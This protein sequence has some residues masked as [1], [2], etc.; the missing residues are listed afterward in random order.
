MIVNIEKYPIDTK[1]DA[2]GYEKLLQSSISQLTVQGFVALPDF[3]RPCAIDKLTSCI[4]DL[5]RRG[6]G[7]YS[8]DSHNVFLEEEGD[9]ASFQSPTNHPRN[10]LLNSSKL[11]ID[12]RH[13]APHFVELTD[14][15]ESREFINFVGSI[16][17]TELHPSADPHGRYYANVF[18]PGDGLQWHLDRSEYSVSLI[19]R[20]AHVGGKFQFVPNSRRVVEGWDDMPS[21]VIHA[22]AHEASMVVE[23]PD[24]VAGDMYI[25][26]GRDSLHRVSEIAEGTRINLILTYNADPGVR[27]NRYTL[28]KFFGVADPTP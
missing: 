15:Y 4:L 8:C 19:L 23:E 17:G 9:S 1:K 18:R 3:L 7:F 6:V 27:L 20:P 13:L 22:F 26:R 16:L 14:L 12:A 25:F 21:D 10:V 2:S 24:L 5:E 11:I 28:R